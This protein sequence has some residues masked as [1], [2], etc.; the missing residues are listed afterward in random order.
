MKLSGNTL[1]KMKILGIFTLDSLHGL[2]T[3]LSTNELFTSYIGGS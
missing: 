1:L 2:E 3:F